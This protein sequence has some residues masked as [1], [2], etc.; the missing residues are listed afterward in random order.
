MIGFIQGKVIS[1][2]AK[3]LVL[4][5]Q[6][7][8]GY[9]VNYGYLASVNDEMGVHIYHQ[10][11]DSDQS[12]WGFNTLEDKRVFELLKTVNKVGPSK[13]Y[14]LVANLGTSSL[15]DAIILE[16]DAVL[17]SIK[18]IG[19]KMA[20]QII[21]S[22]KDKIKTFGSTVNEITPD[23]DNM[24]ISKAKEN[25]SVQKIDKVLLSDTL[26]ALESLGYNDKNIMPLIHTVYNDSI[27]TSEDLLKQILKEL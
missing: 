16:Q 26:L 5:T 7:G 2:D 4:L 11:T 10:I 3:K 13:A 12:L 19:K 24:N 23:S 8:L 21:L 20:E 25:K 18:G 1:S 27:K 22:L 15:V 6:S 9:E 17:T 14:P